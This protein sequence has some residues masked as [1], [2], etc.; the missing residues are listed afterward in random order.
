MVE[1]AEESTLLCLPVGACEECGPLEVSR[2]NKAQRA[3]RTQTHYTDI[4]VYIRVYICDSV[5]VAG[6]Q[7]A[8]GK[9][10]QNEHNDKRRQQW[11]GRRSRKMTN[12]A[13]GGRARQLGQTKQAELAGSG[14]R[15]GTERSGAGSSS[16]ISGERQTGRAARSELLAVNGNCEPL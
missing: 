1:D 6:K 12:Y 3:T 15:N 8:C 5:F 4:A 11:R 14:R 2:E 13:A 16:H 7:A 10:Y 9:Q